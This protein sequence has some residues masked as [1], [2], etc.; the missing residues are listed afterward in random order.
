M[1]GNARLSGLYPLHQLVSAESTQPGPSPGL[2]LS[3][4]EGTYPK[5]TPLP[6]S[7]P[8]THLS[9]Q[10]A[11]RPNLSLQL[12]QQGKAILASEQPGELTEACGCTAV[13]QLTFALS[14][15][16][17]PGSQEHLPLTL[18]LPISSQSA[19]Q[20]QKLKRLISLPESQQVN[21]PQAHRFWQ[22]T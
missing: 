3:L 1:K 15:A 14:P 22:K 10:R 17:F 5:S 13:Q 4:L 19:S 9:V 7:C 18:C 6:R 8:N 12:G 16:F 11:Y 2:A 21:L 20:C